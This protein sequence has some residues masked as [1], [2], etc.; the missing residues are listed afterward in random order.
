[1]SRVD[2]G[3]TAKKLETFSLLHTNVAGELDKNLCEMHRDLRNKTRK[4]DALIAKVIE[5]G[6][7]LAIYLMS[8][9]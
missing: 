7:E 5:L 8:R 9:I 3:N 2:E 4:C 6:N 1:M